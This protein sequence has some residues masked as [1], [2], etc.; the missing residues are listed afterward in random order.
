MAYWIL[1]KK[2]NK[3]FIAGSIP[4]VV[5]FLNLDSKYPLEKIFSR[6]KKSEY[7]NDNYRIVKFPDIGIKK[8]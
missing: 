4:K 3:P 6:D 5:E 7:E 1:D 8:I 2:S